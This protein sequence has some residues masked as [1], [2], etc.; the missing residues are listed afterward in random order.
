M[1]IYEY[2]KKFYEFLF[3]LS[4]FLFHVTLTNFIKKMDYQL[5]EPNTFIISKNQDD[6]IQNPNYHNILEM[7]KTFML[8]KIQLSRKLAMEKIANKISEMWKRK[9]ATIIE[10][11]LNYREQCAN[12]IQSHWRKNKIRTTVQQIIEKE[13]HCFC[14]TSKIKNVYKLDLRV[15][16]VSPPKH[17]NFNYCDIREL[18]VLYIPKK[19]V[20]NAVIR[21]NF[22]ADDKI[23]IDPTYRTDYDSN[24]NFFNI[25][26]F[27]MFEEYEK[28]RSYELNQLKVEISRK[29]STVEDFSYSQINRNFSFNFARHTIPILKNKNTMKTLTNLPCLKPC[30]KTSDS[31]TNLNGDRRK[32]V[33]FCHNVKTN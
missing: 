30:L 12:L 21:V 19:S 10:Q 16:S 29:I 9:K 3:K 25:I 31:Y 11:I 8:L 6:T 2:M 18:F 1:V 5:E 23:F 14:L 17:L 20:R 27:N 28:E 33:S 24:G 7:K 22:I 32:R 13:K 4:F 15:Y 26:D